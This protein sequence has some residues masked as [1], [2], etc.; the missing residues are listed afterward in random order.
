MTAP[1]VPDHPAACARP[2]CGAPLVR[3]ARGRPPLYCS[4]TCRHLVARKGPAPRLT[5]E[6]DAEAGDATGRPTGHVWLVRLRRGERSVEVATRLGRPSAEYLAR[7]LRELIEV[8]RP[9]EGGE[10]R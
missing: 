8:P 1:S 7:Q 2:G 6:I 9:A 5:V 3:K 10:M 4:A